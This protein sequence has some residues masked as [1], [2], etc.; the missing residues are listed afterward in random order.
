VNPPWTPTEPFR[1]R[2]F[3]TGGHAQTLAGF[4]LRPRLQLPPAEA[5]FVE[6]AA[7]VKVLC[8][9]HWQPARAA[10][11]TLIA[12]HGLEG[13]SD[14]GYLLMLAKKALAAGMNIVRINQRNCGGTDHLA[15]TLYHSGL[16][17][18]IAHVVHH[19]L[20]T[21]GL[22]QIALAGY[23]MGGNLVLKT[24]GEWGTEAPLELKAVVGVCPAMD[25][26][27]CADALSE[28]ANRIYQAYFVHMLKKRLARKAELFPQHFQTRWADGV[29]SVRAFD[30]RVT[31]PFGGYRDASDYYARAAA[32]N[33]VDRIT[34]PTLVLHPLSDPFVRLLPATRAKLLANSNIS[35][36]EPEHGGHCTFLSASGDNHWAESQIIHYLKQVT[37]RNH[38]G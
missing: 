11:L 13:S 2:R 32:A 14:S 25:L 20:R 1:P 9:C 24:A 8:H 38:A 27:A 36:H 31:A 12:V 3:L 29:R 6:V 34:V 37:D 17:A 35:L 30:D 7:G 5:H 18:D 33:V 15:P 4:V 21:E 23:S 19:F 16:S 26:A 10:A 22:R 28:P